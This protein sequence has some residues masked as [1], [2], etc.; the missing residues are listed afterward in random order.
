MV[1]VGPIAPACLHREAV[2]VR[3]AIDE[4][5]VASWCPDCERQ[6]SAD[7][8]LSFVDRYTDLDLLTDAHGPYRRRH[9]AGLSWHWGFALALAIPAAGFVAC[10]VEVIVTW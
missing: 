7:W 9:R 5:L 2:E 1:D 4:E 3:R 8:R 10:W 6:L